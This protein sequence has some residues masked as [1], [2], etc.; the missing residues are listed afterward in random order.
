MNLKVEGLRPHEPGGWT[1]FM[2]LKVRRERLLG[3]GIQH[4]PAGWT[5][6]VHTNTL[7]TD[8]RPVPEQIRIPVVSDT[9][10]SPPKPHP[11]YMVTRA[12]RCRSKS[13]CSRFGLID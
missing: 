5:N 11:P 2:N 4:E 7:W 8:R 1:G 10:F 9:G 12:I 6:V 13:E 3:Q